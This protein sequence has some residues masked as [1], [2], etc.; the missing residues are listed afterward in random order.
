MEVA[1][2]TSL[3]QFFSDLEE[4][5]EVI[6]TETSETN[7]IAPTSVWSL[8]P[9]GAGLE[10]GNL[11]P[12]R[13]TNDAY[14]TLFQLKEYHL[15]EDLYLFVETEV[16]NQGQEAASVGF[17]RKRK[18]K[19]DILCFAK[20][21]QRNE[22][23]KYLGGIILPANSHLKCLVEEATTMANTFFNKEMKLSFETASSKKHFHDHNAPDEILTSGTI[24]RVK[25]HG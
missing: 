12:R 17:A 19:S 2:N 23:V 3:R 15:L 21:I 22:G 1:K 7:H 6:E 4:E 13:L 11:C 20:M 9:L 8:G 25:V 18:R 14:R 5:C 10:H 24:L 16:L